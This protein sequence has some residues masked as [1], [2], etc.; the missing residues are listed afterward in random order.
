MTEV[1]L[2]RHAHVDY[3][4]GMAITAQN[5]LT[6]LGHQMA[7]R[8]AMRCESLGLEILFV[9][10]MIRAQQTADAISRR[11]PNL[12]RIELD[13]LEELSIKDLADHP[14]PPD[15]DMLTWKPAHFRA[16]DERAWER[17]ARAWAFVEAVIAQQGL[18]RVGVVSHAAVL[19]TLL[20]Q[21]LGVGP[22]QRGSAWFE[23]AFAS[24]SCLRVTRTNP[25]GIRERAVRWTNDT[26]HLDGL[27]APHAGA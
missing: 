21:F 10:T 3:G 5:P 9:S 27:D 22:A 23:L 25:G 11:F 12:P 20:R 7:E 1:Y 24:V 13:D 15:E 14:S 16:A 17:V 26:R 18:E 8:L 2:F 4:E 6:D 19:N